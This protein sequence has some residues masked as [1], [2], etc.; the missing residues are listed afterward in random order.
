LSK[1]SRRHILRTAGAISACHLLPQLRAGAAIQTSVGN[2]ALLNEKALEQISFSSASDGVFNFLLT[3]CTLNPPGTDFWRNP[4]DSG[5]T[6]DQNQDGWQGAQAIQSAIINY[7]ATGQEKYLKV[8]RDF[9]D[10]IEHRYSGK[11]NLVLCE[12]WP[13]WDMTTHQPTGEIAPHFSIWSDDSGWIVNLYLQLYRYAAKERFLELAYQTLVNLDKRWGVDFQSNS[14]GLMYYDHQDRFSIYMAA[15][16]IGALGLFDALRNVDKHKAQNCLVIASKYQ[17]FIENYLHSTGVGQRNITGAEFGVA[18][19]LFEEECTF[20][21]GDKVPPPDAKSKLQHDLFTSPHMMM[22]AAYV[23]FDQAEKLGGD[24]RGINPK[25]R[26]FK[27][28][29]IEA[30]NAFIRIYPQGYMEQSARGEG[31]VIMNLFDTNVNGFGCYWWTKYVV[32]LNPKIYG[33]AILRTAR[34]I[35]TEQGTGD[36]SSPCWNSTNCTLE[37]SHSPFGNETKWVMVRQ[38]GAASMIASAGW[39]ERMYPEVSTGRAMK[40]G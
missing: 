3:N 8:V 5:L 36:V 2:P 33:G 12:T 30:A 25:F 13:G 26:D 14:R 1:V 24:I 7:E 10:W 17:N 31:T 18:D 23:M 37:R 9:S 39:I 22:T 29:A 6:P 32:P 19:G 11:D 21:Y 15:Q 40:K 4:H 34:Q 27:H 16:V 20:G 28:R 35:I 38:A